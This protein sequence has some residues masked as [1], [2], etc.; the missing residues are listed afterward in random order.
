MSLVFLLLSHVE[1]YGYDFGSF[2][3]YTLDQCMDLCLQLCN[4][5]G[6]QYYSF[7]NGKGFTSFY[8]KTLFLNGHRSPDF[9]VAYLRLSKRYNFSYKN[10]VE[11]SNLDCSREGTIQ[12]DRTYIKNHEKGT[13]KFMLWFACGVGGL[14]L[15]CVFVVCC[16]LIKTRKSSRADKQG[17]ALAATRFRKFTYS[18]LKKATQGFTKE[19]GRG[20]WGAVYKGVLSDNRVAAIK[21]LNEANQGEDVFLVEV[22]IIGRLLV[23]EYMKHGYLAENLFSNA[24]DW[25]QKF[26]I[27]LQN[28][29]G[30]NNSSFSR[31]RGTHSYM[32][33]E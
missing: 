27:S 14:E 26:E 33:P 19:I 2:P 15:T 25:K 29:S 20:A 12:S 13:M 5:E 22:G 4:C 30:I 31:M 18:E 8:L 28:R 16:L 32:V 21:R 11:E 24:L 23:Y 9:R 1:F 10:P 3:S 17:F 7:D 6:F